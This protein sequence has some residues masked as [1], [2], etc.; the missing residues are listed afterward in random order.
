MQ[1]DGEFPMDPVMARALALMLLRG[2]VN[3]TVAPYGTV[4]LIEVGLAP[5]L[6]GPLAALAAIATLLAAPTWGRLGDRHGRRRLLAL[7]LLIAAPVAAAHA[8]PVV[9]VV[10]VAYVAWAFVASAFIPLSDSLILAR[11]RGDRSSFS[12]ARVGASGAY[13]VMVVVIGGLVS[14]SALG[15]AG[16]GVMGAVMC[17]VAA[18]AVISRLRGEL[19]TGSGVAIRSETRLVAGILAGVRRNRWFLVGLAL[20]FAGSNAPSI[21]TGPRVAEVGGTGWEVGLTIAAGTLVEVPAFLTLP[22]LLELFGGRRMFVAG[23]LLLGVAGLTTALAPTPELLIAARLLFGAGY[24][25]TVLPSLAAIS[26]AAA[27]DEHAASAALHFA[28]QAG[29]SLLVALAGLPLVAATGSVVS[30]L[31]AAAIVAPIGAVIGLRAW[32]AS[33]TPGPTAPTSSGA[34]KTA[35]AVTA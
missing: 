5:A 14:V 11:L 15:W 33:G 34:T 24:A 30:V 23:G 13:M 7:T 20:V 19:L 32:P 10:A 17:L 3:G 16:P 31:A 9:P 12:R 29:G 2:A 18:T 28:T 1:R 35:D 6:L 4:I 25:W 22:W 26:A 27:H 21:F 8:I